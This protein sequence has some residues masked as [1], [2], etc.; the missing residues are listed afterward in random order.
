M[1]KILF[2]ESY[3]IVVESGGKIEPS[4]CS[5]LTYLEIILLIVIYVIYLNLKSNAEEA[6]KCD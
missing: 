5:V 4:S 6:T 3:P 2:D 1:E